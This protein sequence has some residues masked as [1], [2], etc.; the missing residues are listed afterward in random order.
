M[1]EIIVFIQAEGRE[2][3]FDLKV[4]AST[5]WAALAERVRELGGSLG[6]AAVVLIEDRDD[7]IPGETEVG[8]LRGADGTVRVHVHRCH[9]VDVTVFYFGREALKQVFR[10]SSTLARLKTWAGKQWAIGPNDL[11]ELSLEIA[12]TTK[13]PPGDT[14]LGS[15]VAHGTCSIAFNLV[16]TKRVQG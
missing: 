14:H 12:G 3:L 1:D 8:R 5:S 11:A 6:P 15:L 10:P 7:E 9:H 16:F 4:P 2:E 13:R